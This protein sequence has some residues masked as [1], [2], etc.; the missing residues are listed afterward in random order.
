VL[1]KVEQ[2]KSMINN[3]R[4]VRITP[5]TTE[6]LPLLLRDTPIY[7]QVPIVNF[8]GLH[9]RQGEVFREPM[10]GRAH[11]LSLS[12]RRLGLQQVEEQELL[13]K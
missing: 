10:R 2:G 11:F 7:P 13:R 8:R 12:F 1:R 4:K 5:I 6:N 9:L 3:L